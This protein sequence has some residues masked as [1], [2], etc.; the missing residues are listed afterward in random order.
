MNQLGV[1]QEE[2]A[3]LI[4]DISKYRRQKIELEG[5]IPEMVDVWIMFSQFRTY[6]EKDFE[7]EKN[8]AMV[9]FEKK[10]KAGD[11]FE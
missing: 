8:K 3:E 10:V 7:E 1:F 4:Q 9:E 5:L 11:A 6:M 2:M